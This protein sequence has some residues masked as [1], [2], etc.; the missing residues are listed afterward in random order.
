MAQKAAG[1]GGPVTR[2]PF[3]FPVLL[4]LA[5]RYL[6]PRLGLV[7]L[8]LLGSLL[9]VSVLPVAVTLSYS[10]ITNFFQSQSPVS[11]D[12]KP[13][14]A[15]QPAASQPDGAA[16]EQP[17]PGGPAPG[18]RD[19]QRTYALWVALLL[20]GAAIVFGHRYLTAYF[21]GKIANAIRADV[22]SAILRQSPAFF[23]RHDSDRLT[24]IVNQFCVQTQMALRQLVIDPV[25]QAV[26]VVIIGITLFQSLS[27]LATDKGSQVWVLFGIILAFALLAPTLVTLSARRLQ[28][29]A[30]MVQH[31]NLALASLV[32]GALAAPEEIQA[33]RAER[34]FADK[35]HALLETSL[36][37]RLGQSVTVE[38]LNAM[39]RLP[40]D[41]VLILLIGLAVYLAVTGAGG[42]EPGTIVAIG[43]LSPQLMGAVQGLSSFTIS[44]SMSW[45]AVDTVN[46]ILETG[47]PPAGDPRE[48]DIPAIEPRVEARDLVFSYRPGELRN[49]LDGV[50]FELPPGRVTGFIARPG[51]GK[52]TFF[53][54]ALRFYQ[55]QQGEILI[56][57]HP[58]GEFT[59][60]SLRRH[61][62][63]MSQF[64]AFF[65]GTTRDNFRV[66][67]PDATDGEIRELCERT[68]LWPILEA[69]IGTDPLD[70]EFAA[71]KML[72]GGQKKLFALTRCLITNPSILL[73]DEPTVGMG[74]L[75]KFPLIQTMQK[76]CEGKTV[77][78]VDHDIL[79]QVQFCHYFIV[80]E[81]G[82]IVQRGSA[83]E[84]MAQGGLFKQ[85]Y[86]EASGSARAGEGPPAGARKL[87]GPEPKGGGGGVSAVRTA[88]R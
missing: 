51:R 10:R 16:A 50:S 8:Y 7:S 39:G 53:R 24:M 48:R 80:L 86:D 28:Q 47:A 3:R 41:V 19:L 45:P 83:Q 2:S 56:G 68:S 67:R 37:S 59:L 82:K 73:M 33:M 1:A 32:G 78:V 5:G 22:F 71:G 54:L 31:H 72:S 21:D 70:Q 34:F 40:S 65:Y 58:A 87:P 4:D 27:A 55:P 38:R 84:L 66:A 13:G 30:S 64:P 44:A 69:N 81:E 75:E 20:G 15:G 61:V 63:L 23:H 43:L 60:E 29:D 18:T 49:V 6:K 17:A 26:G 36:R 79:W 57:G 74:P 85:L 35:H 46:G 77:I 25:M 42:L 12:A 62:V 88:E 11:G 52:T 14:A 9:T 76:A